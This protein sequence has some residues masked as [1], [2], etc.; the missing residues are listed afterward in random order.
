MQQIANSFHVLV[1]DYGSLIFLCISTGILL[2]I[3]IT[4]SF[5]LL[6]HRASIAKLKESGIESQGI[7]TSVWGQHGIRIS[8]EFNTFTGEQC[9]G[10]EIITVAAWP[11]PKER[12]GSS[13]IILY[14]E[15]NPTICS[16]KEYLPKRLNSLNFCAI[17]LIIFLIIEFAG[18]FFFAYEL[19][20][21]RR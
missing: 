21:N 7:I 1:F 10:E 5:R 20:G 13:I 11:P 4:I 18:M 14:L 3:T 6:Q 8:Y 16:I 2:V 19:Y 15:A 9:T 12:A 17:A